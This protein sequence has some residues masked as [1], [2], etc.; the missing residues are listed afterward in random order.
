MTDLLHPPAHRF[1]PSGPPRFNHV[2]M[3]LPADLLGQESRDEI[4]TFFGEVLGFEEMPTMTEDRRRLILGCVHWDQFIFLI[5]GDNPMQCPR[6]DHYGFS[7]GSLDELQGI[8]DRAEAFRQKDD[9]VDLIDLHVDDQG[10]V[11]IHSVYVHY[12]LPMMCEFQYW[13]FAT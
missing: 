12:I 7:V 9:R 6:M 4:C 2:A 5:A 13:E 1:Y 8:A 11:R 3:S 10:V